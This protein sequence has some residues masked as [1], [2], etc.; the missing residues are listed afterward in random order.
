M[1]AAIMVATAVRKAPN[2]A[3]KAARI[4]TESPGSLPGRSIAS[5]QVVEE[6]TAASQQLGIPFGGLAIRKG[7]SG[8]A[9]PSRGGFALVEERFRS[10]F[11]GSHTSEQK[12]SSSGPDFLFFPV[13]NSHSSPACWRRVGRE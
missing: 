4:A 11:N 10:H 7:P 13:V 5:L 8:F 1:K 12:A 2:N 9:S 3:R 6:S